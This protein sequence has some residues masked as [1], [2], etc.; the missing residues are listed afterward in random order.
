MAAAAHVDVLVAA[1]Q[2][3]RFVL[4][5]RIPGAPAADPLVVL[6][7][8]GVGEVGVEGRLEGALVDRSPVAG[9]RG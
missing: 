9:Q 2:A 7:D 5:G 3:A 6:A 1:G 4:V 8:A